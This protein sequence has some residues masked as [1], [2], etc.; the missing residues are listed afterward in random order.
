M[1]AHAFN[2]STQETET[3]ELEASLVEL[4]EWGYLNSRTVISPHFSLSLWTPVPVGYLYFSFSLHI[5][6][7]KISS[8]LISS[9]LCYIR[10]TWHK[11]YLKA[12]QKLTGWVK[13]LPF[14]I[15]ALLLTSFILVQGMQTKM[16]TQSITPWT[17][18]FPGL[19]KMVPIW[20]FYRIL[21][22]NA[23]GL[24]DFLWRKGD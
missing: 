7:Y 23:C 9:T 24:R 15:G 16:C 6:L 22:Y 1:V 4:K 11:E 8:I 19:C 18:P 17:S 13:V 21:R 5:T 3:G 12:H 20:F 14:S 10:N 2:P